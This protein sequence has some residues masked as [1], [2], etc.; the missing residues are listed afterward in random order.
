MAGA[1]GR[2]G[3]G[4]TGAP[5]GSTHSANPL[6]GLTTASLH[7]AVAGGGGALEASGVCGVGAGAAAEAIAQPSNA[8]LI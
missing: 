5:R 8:T 6:T 1:S 4:A 2:F 3:G 7:C